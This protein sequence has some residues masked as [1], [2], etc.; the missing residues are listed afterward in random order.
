MV[1]I[2]TD[3]AGYR[4]STS[5]D[6]QLV[7]ESWGF[8]DVTTATTFER[9][10]LEACTRMQQLRSCDWNAA[11][12]RPQAE[13]GRMA[14]RNLMIRLCA[15]RV[16]DCQIRADNALTMMQLSRLARESGLAL[17]KLRGSSL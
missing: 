14:I 4:I 16:S 6:A 1:S 11:N 5:E 12:L 13:H 7:I 8:W 3:G 9:D 10:A 17:A 15:M 2:G